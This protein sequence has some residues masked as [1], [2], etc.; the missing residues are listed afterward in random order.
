MDPRRRALLAFLAAVAAALRPALAQDRI[1]TKQIPSTREPLPIIGVGT[2]Q[3]FD[4]GA[5]NSAR[6]PLREVLKL[7]TGNVVDSSP[8][9][10]TSESVAG[11]LVA[12]LGLREQLFMATKV[13]T[14][15]RDAGIKQ[16]ETSFKRLRVQTMDLMQVHNLVDVDTHTKT[17]L[18]L[19][20]QRKIRYVGITHYTSSAYAEVERQM[21]KSQ[22]DFL[23]I[24]YSLG[25]RESENRVLGLARDRNMAVIINRPFAE[26]ALF[27][28]TKN[29]PLPPWAAE[30]GIDSWAQYFLKWIV[31]HPAVT[32]AIPGTGNPKH[33]ADNLG[34]GRGPLP[35]T[36]ARKRMTDYFDGL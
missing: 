2:W 34:A 31:S 13:W 4:V 21:K 29:K 27:R 15:G 35:D 14:S 33:M 12:E 32:C 18:D 7:L 11:D 9:Y 26:G 23:Q 8:M 22:Y 5:D 19:K 10:G 25:E 1:M 17:L 6:A 24:N 36:A 16:M 3:T 20:S 30:L 28:K